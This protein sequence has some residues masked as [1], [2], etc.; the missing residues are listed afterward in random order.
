MVCCYV[1]TLCL[2]SDKEQNIRG[3]WTPGTD[4]LV[5]PLR[6]FPFANHYKKRKDATHA[7][8]FHVFLSCEEVF[9]MNS[10]F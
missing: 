3:L 4:S 5:P 2:T 8:L 7:P 6:P 10:V 1:N 9:S